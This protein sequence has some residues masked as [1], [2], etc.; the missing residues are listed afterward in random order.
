MLVD[1]VTAVIVV[2]TVVQLVFL[3]GQTDGGKQHGVAAIGKLF[4][5]MDVFQM[6]R[7]GQALVCKEGAKRLLR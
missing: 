4:L 6:R 1:G 3:H 2:V 7:K 5:G